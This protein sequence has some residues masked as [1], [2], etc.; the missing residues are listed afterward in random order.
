MEIFRNIISIERGNGKELVRVPQKGE[1]LQDFDPIHR[2][3]K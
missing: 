2:L 1:E 3:L